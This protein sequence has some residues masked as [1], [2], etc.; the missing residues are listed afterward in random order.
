MDGMSM[1]TNSIDA[2]NVVNTLVSSNNK[3]TLLNRKV[4]QSN[5]TD[6]NKYKL[7]FL[8]PFSIDIRIYFTL[9]S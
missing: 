2:N 6:K 9:N 8:V 4:E 5:T 3:H 1:K 7:T